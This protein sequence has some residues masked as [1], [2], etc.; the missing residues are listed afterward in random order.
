MFKDLS[1]LMTETWRLFTEMAPYLLFGFFIAG[2]LHI[3][4]PRE[5]IYRHFSRN[6]FF[7]VV[8]AALFGIPLPLCSCGVIPVAAHLRKEGAGKGA[9]MAFL[10]STPVTGIDSLLA[11]YSLLGLLFAVVRPAAS[12]FAG[13]L[14]GSLFLLNNRE[15]RPAAPDTFSCALCSVP[16]RH[17]HSFLEKIAGMLRYAFVDLIRDTGKW[18]LAGILIGG[19]ISYFVPGDFI[20]RYL[21]TPYL[22]YP[23]MILA[24]IPMYVC[25]TGSIPIAASLILKGMTPG[26]GLV[27][28]ITGPA[29]NTATISFV[30]GRLGKKALVIYLFSIT[31][32]AVLFGL[33][34]DLLWAGSGKDIRVLMPG[35]T[36]V[37][38]HAASA[39]AFLL[40]ALILASFIKRNNKTVRGAAVTC[41]VPDMECDHCVRT[42]KQ[43]LSGLDGVKEVA[44]DL[45]KKEVRLTGRVTEEEARKTINRAGYTALPPKE[46]S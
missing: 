46:E 33:L 8:K 43:A 27:F 42:I 28:L 39:A 40:A 19:A 29:T 35:M 20:Q 3:L 18:L 24:G 13:L 17:S 1:G 5:K 11:T 41:I 34:I 22:A 4:I 12:L 15:R 10:V 16:E 37:P 31:A 38:H 26:A 30:L 6:D 25:A 9:T 2:L 7:S 45:K 23:L 44:V 14:A 21:G 36:M 32:S